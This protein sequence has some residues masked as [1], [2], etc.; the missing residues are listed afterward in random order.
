MKGDAVL[1]LGLGLGLVLIAWYA[2]KAA[3]DAMDD[4]ERTIRTAWESAKTGA[5]AVV[6][7]T[8][9]AVTPAGAA[10]YDPRPPAGRGTQKTQYTLGDINDGA[11]L[12]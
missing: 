11:I 8:V 2:K 7:A 1:V 9:E 3:G 4:A 5:V 6:D 12:M 10:L